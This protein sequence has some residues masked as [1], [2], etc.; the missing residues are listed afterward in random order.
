MKQNLFGKQLFKG[1]KIA[2]FMLMSCFYSV[3]FLFAFSPSLQGKQLERVAGLLSHQ[4]H[5]STIFVFHALVVLCQ[6][7]LNLNL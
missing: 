4:I 3:V 7:E 2:S 5:I 1:G 6:D